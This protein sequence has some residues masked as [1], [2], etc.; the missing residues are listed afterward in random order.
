MNRHL[1]HRGPDGDGFFTEN[2]L[3]LG[4]VRLS[5]LDLTSAG[6]QPM[7][8]NQWVLT[9][10][11]EIYNFKDLRDKLTNRGYQF[12]SRSDTEVLLKAWDCWGEKCLHQLEGMFA[13]AILDRHERCLSIC[14]DGYGVKPLFYSHI[15][16]E[17]LFSSELATLVHA[18][19]VAPQPDRDALG[20]FLALHYVPAPQTGLN[21][22]CKLPAGHFISVKFSE[23]GLLVSDP[24]SWHQPF[25]PINTEEGI[26]LDELDRAL[27]HSVRQQM[28]SDVPVGAFLSGGVDSSLICHYATKVHREPLHTFSI[29]FSDAGSEYDETLYA[30]QAAKIIGAEHH[31][32]QVEL[33]GLSNRI[34]DIL[35]HMGELNADSSVFLNHIVC[36]EARKYVTVCLSGAGGDEMFGGYFRHQA[37]LA[38][39]LLNRVPKPMIRVIRTLLNPLPQ[40]RDNRLGNFVRRLIR[41]IDQRNLKNSN[42][43]TLLR[44]DRIYP[45]DSNFLNHPSVDTLLKALEFDFKHFL[46]DNILSFSD[47]MSML[48]GLEVRV[49][50]LDPGVVHLAE[51]MRNNQ[52]V[53][54][55]EKKVLL[56]QLAIRYFPRDLIYR[57]KQGFA[58]PLEVWLRQLSKTELKRRCLG[59]LT[60]ELVSEQVTVDLIN[61]FIDHK[62]DLSL[63][64]YAL[65]VANKWHENLISKH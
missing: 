1:G 44:Q 48:H 5:I 40:N 62:K 39:E 46:G 37:L 33:G 24:T 43:L 64:I 30:A 3:A 57:K 53:T 7:Q 35:D 6:A 21:G 29:G 18:Q 9:F 32:I 59:A 60:S 56:K 55:K 16:S 61:S 4:H 25:R 11:G 22:I 19:P 58:A 65:I 54:L 51:Q 2:S 17:F 38:L 13:F 8:F 28:V 41:F 45:Q 50:F 63:Q 20:T 31:A 34:D 23:T 47:K 12:E 36:A 42:F 10:N 49:P 52:R 26:A 15:N 14:R 27:A